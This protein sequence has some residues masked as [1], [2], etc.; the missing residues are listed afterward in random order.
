[1]RQSYS[2]MAQAERALG[3]NRALQRSLR[4]QL[5]VINA[6]LEEVEREWLAAASATETMLRGAEEEGH[7][8]E[9]REDDTTYL[10]QLQEMVQRHKP[11]QDESW[12]KH[13]EQRL[14][15]SVDAHQGHHW[16]SVAS[17]V[18]R[19]SLQCLLHYQRA[20]NCALLRSNWTAEEDANLIAARE[21]LGNGDWQAIASR[22]TGRTRTQC[23]ERWVKSLAPA[24]IKGKWTADEEQRLALAVKAYGT[25]WRRLAPHVPS[26]TDAQCREKWVNVLSPQL[27][28]ADWTPDE[29]SMLKEA[30]ARLGVG[31]WAAVARSLPTK[32]T[33][34]QC[35]RR[36]KNVLADVDETHAASSAR[37]V[38]HG[39]L[40]R[41]NAATAKL[42]AT[43]FFLT[44]VE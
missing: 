37:A 31:N 35:Y 22:V 3:I 28:K 39:A 29:D 24:T 25:D 16:E 8:R 41:V 43:D 34:S 1:M 13:E 44:L 26:R 42:D 4:Q 23:R 21:E 19:P 33:D 10:S 6:A 20:L 30:V 40:P 17:I 18:G 15:V 14:L 38:R 12:T 7:S 32:R 9:E 2:R 5:E 11:M 36:W 27:R